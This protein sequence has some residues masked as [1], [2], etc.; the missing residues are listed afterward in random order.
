MGI[1]D[2]IYSASNKDATAFEQQFNSLV[3]HRIDSAIS[4]KYDS[5]FESKS[6]EDD[7]EDDEDGDDQLDKLSK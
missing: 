6:I 3:T 1:R 5:M 4:A 7:D 2:L